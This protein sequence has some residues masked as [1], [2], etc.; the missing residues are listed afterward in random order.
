MGQS[1]SNINY[2]IVCLLL[3]SQERSNMLDIRT[4]EEER[5]K[6]FIEQENYKKY[7]KDKPF[8]SD[9]VH[10]Q[11]SMLDLMERNKQAKEKN[12]AMNFVFWVILFVIFLILCGAA[13]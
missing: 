4:T 5:Q 6:Y 12:D 7:Y 2:Q 10:M 1:V 13:L 8:Y 11:M 9:S 3:L